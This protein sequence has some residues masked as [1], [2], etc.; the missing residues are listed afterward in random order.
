MHNSDENIRVEEMQRRGLEA[1]GQI[2]LHS[3]VANPERVE[4]AMSS[5]PSPNLK[6]TEVAFTV[7]E[8]QNFWFAHLFTGRTL[9]KTIPP[10]ASS[11]ICVFCV[12]ISVMIGD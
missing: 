4:R 5:M 2:K 8:A 3:T 12:T 7:T 9:T 6:L 11:A 10:G 1:T